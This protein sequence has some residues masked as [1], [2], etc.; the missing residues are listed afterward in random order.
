M[1]IEGR[2][3]LQ[4]HYYEDGNVQL[5]TDTVKAV[6]VNTTSD[7][8]AS[9]AAVVKA[10]TTVEQNFHQALDASYNIMGETT[11]KALRRALPISGQK[12]NWNL[13]HT[14]R[15]GSEAAGGK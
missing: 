13:I 10:V 8:A 9:A 3:R 4:V 5:H 6:K 12:I 11:C 14:Y 7:P 1:Q 2:I 15:V